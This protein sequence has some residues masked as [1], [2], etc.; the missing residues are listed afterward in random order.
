MNYKLKTNEKHGFLQISPT[1]SQEEI[2]DFYKKEF[3]SGDYKH[4]NDS[5]LEVQLKDRDYYESLWEDVYY[6]VD[7]LNKVDSRDTKWLDIGCGFALALTHW[8]KK[9][10]KGWGFDPATEAVEYAKKQGINAVLAGM[11]NMNP[12]PDEK[13]DV[14]TLMNVLEH[15]SDPSDVIQQI[16]SKTLNKGGILVIDVPN[17]F[18]WMQQAAVETHSL[19]QW[20]VAPP[21]HLNYFNRKSLTSLLEGNGFE[22]VTT[23]SSFPLELFLLFGDN[24]VGNNELGSVCHQKRVAFEKNIRCSG[25]INDL[26]N[27]YRKLSEADVGRQITVI[28]RAS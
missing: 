3:Y 24:Y 10:V 4:F 25:K 12:F 21:G 6:Y 27:M 28:A 13:F 8:M 2:I 18:S 5:A 22:V 19:K 17:E 14:V 16:H 20:W 15:L 26:R 9:G 1:P 7:Q 11:D 23:Y